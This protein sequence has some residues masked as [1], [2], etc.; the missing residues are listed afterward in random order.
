MARRAARIVVLR[1]VR[2]PASAAVTAE[3]GAAPIAVLRAERPRARARVVV[4]AEA[5]AALI[6]LLRADRPRVAV[7]AT[8]APR[9]QRVGA[10]RARSLLVSARYASTPRA[11][12]CVATSRPTMPGAPMRLAVALGRP[13]R[14]ATVRAVAP[15]G[16]RSGRATA[17]AML[18]AVV[19]DGRRSGRATAVAMLHVAGRGRPLRVATVRAAVQVPGGRSRRARARLRAAVAM[20]HAVVARSPREVRAPGAPSSHVMPVRRRV[21]PRDRRATKGAG[22]I[23]RAVRAAATRRRSGC[24]N[25]IR[26]RVVAAHVHL[27]RAVRAARAARSAR[28]PTSGAELRSTAHETWAC[29]SAQRCEVISTLRPRLSAGLALW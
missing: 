28:S 6:A 19:P 1:A 7:R 29:S 12:A 27:D 5:R 16:R 25:R 15:D 10:P 20:L 8:A 11:R 21:A 18:R 24:R 13:L 2:A 23:A 3:P 9:A 26:S 4:T 17:V 14:A 22:V